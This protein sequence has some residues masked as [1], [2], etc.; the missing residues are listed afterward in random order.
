MLS[1][2]KIIENFE[3]ATVACDQTIHSLRQSQIKEEDAR[4]NF[5]NKIRTLNNMFR[6]SYG[7]YT[8]YLL[9]HKFWEDNY[10][11]FIMSNKNM[12]NICEEYDM[13]I[14]S[15]FIT[16]IYS[17]FESSF[18]IIIQKID[19]IYYEKNKTHFSRMAEKVLNDFKI[20]EEYQLVKH[21]SNLR[22]SMHS[23]GFF[24]PPNSKDQTIHYKNKTFVYKVGEPVQYAGWTD[25]ISI[26]KLI[27]YL[28]FEIINHTLAQNIL[29]IKEPASDFWDKL[30]DTLPNS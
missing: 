5:Y 26:S 2:D 21:F 10:P 28:F 20:P 12:S 27:H 8:K 30:D 23:N 6:L 9:T 3:L 15:T 18:R 11:D 13:F 4:L 16:E 22:N 7:F 19:P 17:A 29:F 24:E 14:R 25:L 1:D